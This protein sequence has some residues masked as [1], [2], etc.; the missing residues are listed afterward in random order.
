MQGFA[1]FY[2]NKVV[3]KKE[4]EEKKFVLCHPLDDDCVAFARLRNEKEHRF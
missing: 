2:V 4:N 3:Y 1:E